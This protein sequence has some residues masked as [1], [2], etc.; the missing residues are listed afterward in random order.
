MKT[1][2]NIRVRDI[3]PGAWLATIV[4]LIFAVA[5]CASAP[6]QDKTLAGA[7]TATAFTKDT[8]GG[9]AIVPGVSIEVSGPTQAMGVTDAEGRVTF[10]DLAPGAYTLT[11]T[12]PDLTASLQISVTEGVTTQVDVE[13][14][15]AAVKESTTVTASAESVDTKEPSGK[16]SIGEST[17]ENVPNANEKFESVLPLVPGVVRGPSGTINLKGARA[18]ESGALVNSADVTDPVT[19]AKAINIPIDVV[20]SVQVLSTPYDPQ[21]GRF[22]GAVASVETRPGS[23]NG[24]RFSAQN[25]LPRV[26]KLGDSYMGIEAATPRMTLSMPIIKDKVAFTESVEYRY[27][28][29]PVDSLPKL[30]RD[31]QTESFESYSQFDVNVSQ[32]QTATASFAVFPQKLNYYGLNTFTPQ[33]STPDVHSRGY[34]AYLQ[35]RYITTSSDL[36]TSQFSFRRFDT[37]VFANG[38]GAYELLVD[39]TQGSFFNRQRRDTTR[40]EWS[41]LFQSHPHSFHGSHQFVTGIEYAHSSYDGRQEFL[42]VQIIGTEGYALENISFGPKTAFTADQD[43]LAW[44][45]GDKWSVTNRL[46]LDLGARFDRD[47]V[48]DSVNPA[49]RAGFVLALTGDGRTLLK[50]GAGFFFARVPLNVASFRSLPDRTVSTLD[51]EGNV[52]SSTLYSN[53]YANGLRNPRS[54][55]WNLEVDRE[56]TTNLLLRVGYQQRNTVRDFYVSPVA[57]DSTGELMLYNGGRSFYRE[58]QVTGRYQFHKRSTFN[59]SYVRSRAYGDLNDF[60]QFFGNNPTA[61]IEPNQR[62]PLAFDAP[63]RVLAWAEI[64]APYKLTVS[65]LLDLHTGFPYSST[66]ESREFVGPRNEL[67]YPRFV[68]TDIQIL[69]QFRLPIKEKHA[70]VGFAVYNLFN[71]FNPR[72]VQNDLQSYHYGEFYNGVGRTFRGKFVLEF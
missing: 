71:H 10:A 21:Y 59:A 33:A 26:R 1:Q 12:A 27:E 45:A 30:Q 70:R 37:D 54:E 2:F 65:P 53:A 72:D 29:Y 40:V 44:F 56:L 34:Q 38:S 5:L 62:G 57:S 69:R 67:R 6:A 4:T 64:A 3:V 39:T 48:T 15:I 31:T 17:I 63:H 23:F 13:M 28:R 25:F 19:G 36:L 51:S 52:L 47:R 14:T 42:P 9:R 61:V 58:F 18:S 11:A 41:E 35:D 8:D 55:V 66:N 24:F 43:E 32:R 68:S 20:S 49:P 16:N 22:T 60:N 46:T 7:L 50:G